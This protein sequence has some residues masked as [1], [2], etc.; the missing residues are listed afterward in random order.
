MHK[1]ICHLTFSLYLCKIWDRLRCEKVRCV[2]GCKNF[3]RFFCATK[4]VW[5]NTEDIYDG[6]KEA[7]SK[8]DVNSPTGA[9]YALAVARAH[10]PPSASWQLIITLGHGVVQLF[11]YVFFLPLIFWILE[12]MLSFFQELFASLWSFLTFLLLLLLQ[13][14]FLF[15]PVTQSMTK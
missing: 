10:A 2:T 4:R 6:V 9:T 13:C 12:N 11:K 14:S 3:D 15:R 7:G 1:I 8:S 5:Y